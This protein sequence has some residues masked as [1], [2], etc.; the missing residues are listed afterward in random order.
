MFGGFGGFGGQDANQNQQPGGF[1]FPGMNMNANITTSHTTQQTTTSG[2]GMFGSMGGGFGGP[3]AQDDP[4][5]KSTE[6][7]DK[8]KRRQELLPR[9][10]ALVDVLEIK[11]E[12]VTEMR[13]AI[14]G[15]TMT[16]EEM[17]QGMDV[18]EKI[19]AAAMSFNIMEMMK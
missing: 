3:G 18:F 7:Q 8:F 5:K 6:L 2:G 17:K 19:T 16:S 12:N 13:E 14:V 4:S 10:T 11:G 15:A 9:Y 1:G